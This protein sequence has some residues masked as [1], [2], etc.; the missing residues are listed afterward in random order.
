MRFFVVILFLSSAF[1]FTP[2][3]S[4]EAQTREELEA[5]IEVLRETL[6]E[7]KAELQE[8][9]FE[10]NKDFRFERDLNIGSRGR[11][12]EKLQNFL[13]YN[14]QFYPEKMVTG[15]YGELTSAAV[16]RLKIEYNISEPGFGEESRE[17][18][19]DLFQKRS[20]F[21]VSTSG[22]TLEPEGTSDDEDNNDEDPVE[23][24]ANINTSSLARQIHIEVNK[25][26][27]RNGLNAL[28]W[29]EELARVAREH[30]QEQSR[31]NEEITESEY[32][33]Q[34]PIIRHEGFENGFSIRDRVMNSDISFRSVGENI[35][36][37]PAI[38][39]RTYSYGVDEEMPKCPER[40]EFSI[41]DVS[42][43]EEY[44]DYIDGLLDKS[45]SVGSVDFIR[46]KR[47]TE[48]EIVDL[49]IEGWMDSPGHRENILYPD[50]THSG[51]GVVRVNEYLI[52]T[53]NFIGR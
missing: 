50:Y 12:V 30:S 21:V 6:R 29:D 14:T 11:D 36:M 23:G 27:V 31:D 44:L 26:R 17:A 19:N 45:Q 35:A 43:E 13:A 1:F 37:I 7:L 51:I 33:C 22:F 4:A 49:T 24:D 25:T 20:S 48:D 39:S 46:A 47:Y 40:E 10:E 8:K 2:F 42:D 9:L 34:Y 38:K 18:L 32:L 5:R 53:H 3:L 16:T 52:I 28:V 15:Y 41:E